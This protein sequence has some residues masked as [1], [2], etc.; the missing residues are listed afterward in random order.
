MYPLV[1]KKKSQAL[2]SMHEPGGVIYLLRYQIPI[3]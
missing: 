2:E 1:L 3:L